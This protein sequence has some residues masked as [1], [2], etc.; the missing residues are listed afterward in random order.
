MFSGLISLI[1]PCYRAEK[2]LGRMIESVLAQ[3]YQHWELLIVSNGAGQE[4]QLKVVHELMAKDDRIQCISVPEAGVSNA[5]NVGMSLI[6]G[7]F[8]S[9][10]DADDLIAPDHLTRFVEVMDEASEL[11]IAGYTLCRTKE[12][13][14]E[15][16][17]LYLFDSKN[18]PDGM[19]EGWQKYIQMEDSRASASWNKMHRTDT[20]RGIGAR[21]RTDYSTY[22]DTDFYLTLVPHLSRLQCIPM[23]GYQYLCAD[24][25]SIQSRWHPDLE[26]IFSG[27]SVRRSDLRRRMG[28]TD[29]QI[30]EER[31]RQRF[32]EVYWIVCNYYKQGCPLTFG[33]KRKEVARLIS[34]A[35]FRNS[36]PLQNK[37]THNGLMKMFDFAIATDQA[38]FVTLFFAFQYKVKELSGPFRGIIIRALRR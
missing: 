9:F 23:S 38:W 30:E 22:E 3:D 10:L 6:K 31:V 27:L 4:P 26:T 8:F 35:D 18:S 25:S 21:F 34:D 12:N 7:E 20:I 5:R 17:P 16:K 14:Q 1:L 37:A 2:Y 32:M 24:E 33:Q 29:A 28:L 36:V 11:I 15:A 13:S 19:K